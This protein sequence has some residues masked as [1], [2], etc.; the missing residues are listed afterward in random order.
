MYAVIYDEYDP[1]EPMKR[2]LSVHRRRDTAERALVRRMRGLG[3]RVWECRSRVVWVNGMARA[4]DW[5]AP[6][7]FTTWRPGERIPWGETHSDTD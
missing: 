5:L 6:S 1:S 3:R 7:T 2:V 4:N